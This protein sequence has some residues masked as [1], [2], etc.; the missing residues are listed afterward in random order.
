[1]AIG[2]PNRPPDYVSRHNRPF[3]WEEMLTHG[4]YEHM[5]RIVISAGEGTFHV[6]GKGDTPS[7]ENQLKDEIKEAYDKWWYETF[8]SKFLGA[9]GDED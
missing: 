9:S 5:E 1:M 3:W 6:V 8:E 7:Q 4:P 2:K